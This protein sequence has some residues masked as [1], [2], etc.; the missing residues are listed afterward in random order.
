MSGAMMSQAAVAVGPRVGGKV[1]G[2]RRSSIGWRASG[3]VAGTSVAGGAASTNP[4]RNAH[5]AVRRRANLAF[6]YLRSEPLTPNP[7]RRHEQ[8][9]RPF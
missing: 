6:A 5:G 1:S 3:G 4:V 7:R 8:R 9:R 2:P